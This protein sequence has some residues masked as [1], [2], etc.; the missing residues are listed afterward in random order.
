MA[1]D[2]T[3]DPQAT[4]PAGVRTAATSTDWDA[5]ANNA[6]TAFSNAAGDAMDATVSDAVETYGSNLSGTLTGVAHDVDALGRNTVAATN[7]MTN[8]DGHATGILNQQGSTA[9]A[10]HSNLARPIHS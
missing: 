8:S 6:K 4:V 1:N 5:W 3:L 10:D 7:A 9:D 2:I